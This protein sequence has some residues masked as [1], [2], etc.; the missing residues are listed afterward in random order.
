[1]DVITQPWLGL[2]WIHYSK[3]APDPHERV[4]GWVYEYFGATC[5]VVMAP[6]H[7]SKRGT[8]SIILNGAPNPHERVMGWVCEYLEQPAV[9]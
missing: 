1:M 2:K 9:F 4:M 8:K 6:N 7:Y 3:R 5:R